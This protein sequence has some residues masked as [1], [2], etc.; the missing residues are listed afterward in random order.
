MP[1]KSTLPSSWR[2][3]PNPPELQL[4]VLQHP[5]LRSLTET[6]A[7]PRKAKWSVALQWS[8]TWGLNSRNKHHR[9]L[10]TTL[11]KL[12]ELFAVVDINGT[13]ADNGTWQAAAAAAATLQHAGDSVRVVYAR[14]SP[15]QRRVGGWLLP[16]RVRVLWLEDSHNLLFWHWYSPQVSSKHGD[17]V[18][19]RAKLIC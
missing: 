9:L 17:T 3:P 5:H 2:P 10:Q 18:S 16:R 1:Q 6:L 12:I 14:Q 7:G 13:I 8:A 15:H 4:S 11:L 19:R